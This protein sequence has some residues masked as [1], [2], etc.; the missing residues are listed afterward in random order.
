VP[1]A[2]RRKAKDLLDRVGVKDKMNNRSVNLSGGQQQRVAIARA[3]INDPK[4]I[5]ADEPTGNL[6]SDT[7][8]SVRLLLRE[9]NRDCST[10]FIIVTHDRHIAASCDR[11]ID[12]ADG[13]IVGDLRIEASQGGDHW[14]E[15]SP[16]YC[17][18][19]NPKVNTEPSEGAVP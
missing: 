8:E 19:R 17:R 7:G 2:A 5:L 10:T 14:D 4:V 13:C 12:I 6:D 3:L 15:L 11:V 1:E 16:C 9:I 18:L